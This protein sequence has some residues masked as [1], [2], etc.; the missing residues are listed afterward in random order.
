M[1]KSNRL[2]QIDVRQACRLVGECRDLGRD[3][4][5]WMTHFCRGLVCL[6]SAGV[7]TNCVHPT[8]GV[9]DC[10]DVFHYTGVGWLS[11]AHRQRLTE[12][13]MAN[14]HLNELGYRRQQQVWR[15]QMTVRREDLMPR[16][17]YHRLDEFNLVRKFQGVDDYIVMGMQRAG[18]PAALTVVVHRWLNDPV[19]TPRESR[20]LH[21]T[22]LE[23]IRLLGRR[24]AVGPDRLRAGLPPRLAPVLDGLLAGDGE[25]QIAFKLGLSRHTVHEYVGLI[26][27]RYEVHTRAELL[28]LFTRRA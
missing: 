7:V 27:R 10:R 18:G 24:L 4:D 16:R 11:P 22:G 5:A 17:V 6:M 13:F 14:E 3:P 12:Y 15:P 9:R 19:F 25:K 8:G 2:R 21:V 28:A 20:L 23:L 26:Y 1:S